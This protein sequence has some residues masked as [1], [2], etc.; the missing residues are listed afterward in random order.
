[1]GTE[2]TQQ[3]ASGFNSKPESHRAFQ[4]PEELDKGKSNEDDSAKPLN[5][6]DQVLADMEARLDAEREAEI[7]AS[8]SAAPAVDTDDAEAAVEA[9]K[10]AAEAAEEGLAS[11]E[12]MHPE[13]KSD[14][15]ELPEEYW[16]DPLAEF[17]VMDEEN[18]TPMFVT[19]VDGKEVY[20]PLDRA[21]QQLQKHTAAEARLQQAAEQKKALDDR[22]ARILVN[23]QALESRIKEQSNAHHPSG[24]ATDVSDQDFQAEAE[25][26]VQS[27]FNG[28]PEEAAEKLAAVLQNSRTP[29]GQTVDTEA[30]VAQA[31]VQTRQTLAAEDAET[32]ARKGYQTFKTDYPEIASSKKLFDVADGMTE[33]I[34]SEW[35]IEGRMFRTSELMAEAGKRTREWAHSMKAPEEQG[36]KPNNDR[37]D[38]KRK[39]RPMPTSQS[40][41]M[42]PVEEEPAQTP[43]DTL[44]EIK[45]ARGQE[46]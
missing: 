44:A 32:D 29:Q 40:Q 27:L 8:I 43:T 1:M 37:H 31:A 6:R 21:R 34:A 16:D 10:V 39:L 15:G 19:K 3:G 46:A 42:T 28:T 22:E 14:A 12:P 17:I 24:P 26:V 13:E 25:E 11:K 30:I 33:E 9:A 38:R 20:I 35:N 36:S 2:T 4:D 18:N 5:P 23:E 7:A 41:R 45:K